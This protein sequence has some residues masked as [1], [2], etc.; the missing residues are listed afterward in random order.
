LSGDK[1]YLAAAMDLK[2]PK[3]SVSRHLAVVHTPDGKVVYEGSDDGAAVESIAWSPSS[4]YVAVLRKSKGG[5]VGSPLDILSAMFGHPVHYSD[6]WVEVF[7]LKG[8]LVAR[9]K[10]AEDVKASWGE[11][12]W[13]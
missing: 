13:L 12:V 3:D 4:E 7:D 10:I 8:K 9:A 1:K 5:R 6:Y 11:I 2:P